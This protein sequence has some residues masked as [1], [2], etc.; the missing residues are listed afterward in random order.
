ML[1]F[2]TAAWKLAPR[3][4]F[5]EWTPEKRE[6]N[7]LLVVD[8]PNFLTLTWIEIPNSARTSQIAE[9]K[10]RSKWLFGRDP[11]LNLCSCMHFCPKSCLHVDVDWLNRAGT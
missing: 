6:K 4:N 5:I 3:D 11:R 10:C 7:I 2:A 8:N 1:G 9:Q